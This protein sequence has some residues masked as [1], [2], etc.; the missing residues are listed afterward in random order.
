MIDALLRSAYAPAA[1]TVG[2][3]L[4]RRS[5]RPAQL[6]V[7]GLLLG[8]GA[9]AAAAVGLWL[10]ALAALL[11]SRVFDGLDGAVARL[12][13][14]SA[15]GAFADLVA[16]FVVYSGF[17]VAIAIR[18][19]DARLAS[20]VLLAAYCVSVTAFLSWGSLTA[21]SARGGGL[22]IAD[23]RTVRFVSGLAE[24]FETIVAYSLVCLLPQHATTILWIFAG[25]VW[26]TAA[27][28]T[29]FGLRELS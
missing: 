26:F 22:E 10:V 1:T 4:H 13:R 12:E 19:P 24:G 23:D 3:W 27:Q 21:N 11:V 2:R 5:V 9:A 28:R 15:A 29:V 17:V 18:V 6:T 8:L 7:A 16:D 20:V 25:M 14:T